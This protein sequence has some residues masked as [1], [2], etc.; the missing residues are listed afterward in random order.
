[1]TTFVCSAVPATLTL[2][3][4]LHIS[5]LL[6]PPVV[7]S[8]ATLLT[9][10]G[11]SVWTSPPT[12]SS[13]LVMSSST[14]M[15]FPS[16]AQPH[17]PILTPSSSPI[18]FLPHLRLPVL[19][20][21]LLLVRS[22]RP[23]P[24]HARLRRPRLRHARPRQ[25]CLRPARPRRPHLRH[26]RPRR[27]RLRHARPRRP[28]LRHTRPRRPRLRHARPRRP[29][30]CHARPR[31]PR[32]AS[33]TSHSSTIAAATPLPRR[34]PIGPV[35]ELGPF[36]RPCRRLSPPRTGHPRRSRRS[37][38]SLR[39]VRLP[40]G[41]HPPRPRAR[42]PDGDSARCWRSP[43]RRPADPGSCYI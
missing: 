13:S 6:A 29:R 5:F 27:P 28:R 23:L 16:L 1:M 26:A 11:T 25:S 14:K 3:P 34:P 43:P 19:H 4:P 17:P 7:Y 24:R 30:L 10:R 20:R 32:L 31:R 36:R 41:R 37:G 9:T 39:V 2:P 22:R 21:Y 33:P 42:P 12:A 18:R 15:C 35:D 8:L 40:P 38:G